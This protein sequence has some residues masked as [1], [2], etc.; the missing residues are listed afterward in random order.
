M[1]AKRRKKYAHVL[2]SIDGDTQSVAKTLQRLPN[3][4]Y[5]R[6]HPKTQSGLRPLKKKAKRAR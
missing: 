4:A 1:K 3:V 2:V 5:V 6:Y